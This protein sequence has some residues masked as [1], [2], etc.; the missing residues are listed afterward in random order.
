MPDA[1]AVI[2]FR[3]EFRFAV[4]PEAVWDFIERTGEFERLWAWLGEFRLEGP[5]LQAGSVLVGEVSPPVPYRMRVQVVLGDCIRP[6]SIDAAVHGDLE[7][8]ARLTIVGERG[9]S[10][11]T[12]AWRIEMMQRAMRIADRVAH[13]LLR[14]GHDRVVDATVLSFRRHIEA[15]AASGGPGVTEGGP[16]PAPQPRSPHPTTGPAA[17]AR[18]GRA[19]SRRRS[20]GSTRRSG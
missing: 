20:R 7:G 5:G 3:D 14:W 13:P 6:T 15:G 12:V 18:A 11:V 8:T 10:L 17:P 16:A 4:A 9:G 2:D 1:P 19:R